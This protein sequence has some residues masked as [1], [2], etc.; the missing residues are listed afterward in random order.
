MKTHSAKLSGKVFLVGAGP[1][2]VDLLTVK[3]V[4]LLGQADVVLVDDLAGDAVLQLC[5]QARVIHVG[6]R[7][8]C[9]ST[10]QSFI[11]KLLVR[12]AKSGH[13]VVRLK[14]GDPSIFGRAGEEIAALDAAG[15][16]FEIVPG[17]SSG[18]AAAAQL[19]VSLTHRDHAQGVAFITAHGIEGAAVPWQALAQGNL[20]LVVY[21]GVARSAELRASL[22]AGGLPSSTPVIAVENVSRNDSR[23]VVSTVSDMV[24]DFA[25]HALKSPSVIVIGEALRARATA[26][27]A[28]AVSRSERALQLRG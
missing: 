22:I 20:T 11:E 13:I 21:M 3:A 14:G 26:L 27:A 15:I 4:R 6:K 7:G 25:T 19:G 17:V 8:G 1:G 24:D 9:K 18:V 16:D 5:Q 12:E 10:P 28:D 2:D 23:T